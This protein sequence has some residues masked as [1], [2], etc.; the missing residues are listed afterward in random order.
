MEVQQ[1]QMV[2][3][4]LV[5]S[6]STV[7]RSSANPV[8]M[9]TLLVIYGLSACDEQPT[10]TGPHLLTARAVN[11]AAVTASECTP[12]TRGRGL[13]DRLGF[14]SISALPAVGTIRVGDT[15][16]LRVEGRRVDGT[17][18]V[19]E[20]FSTAV[21]GQALRVAS[22]SRLVG[23][24]EGSATVRVTCGDM[25]SEANITV[26]G[27]GA[28]GGVADS[29]RLVADLSVLRFDGR[30]D[31]A[32]VSN[33]IPLPAGLVRPVD[34][35]TLRVMVEGQEMAVAVGSLGA[36][37][38][39]GTVR[40]VLVQFRT[41]VP[42]LGA[43]RGQLRLGGL[44]T[45]A[46]IPIV[47]APRN[48]Q[49]VALPNSPE[50]LRQTGLTGPLPPKPLLGVTLDMFQHDADFGRLE[51]IDWARCGA[52]WSCGRTAGYD[53]ALSLYQEW[54]RTGNP[55]YFHHANANVDDYL[56]QYIEPNKVPAPWW[57]NSESIAINYL[58]TGAPSSRV[59][60]RK[61]AEGL[62]EWVRETVWFSQKVATGEDRDR[63]RALVAALDAANVGVL[64]PVAELAVTAAR[65]YL[66]S[67][68][69]E[70]WMQMM[71]LSQDSRGCFCSSYFSN[72][73]KNFMVGLYLQALI[74]YYDERRQ[75]PAVLTMIRKSADYMWQYEWD[76]QKRGFKY[77]TNA[78]YDATGVVVEQ[79][80]VFPDLN[81]LIAPA[82]A[83][84]YARTGETKYAEQYDL[85][86]RGIRQDPS[87]MQQSGKAFDQGYY[88][89]ANGYY[90]RFAR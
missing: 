10:G 51:G 45:A 18:A 82:Y 6:M 71:V 5:H 21:S 19:L 84:L 50:Y 74:R 44:R 46:S 23:A 16:G 36:L 63:A 2:E 90:W 79:P 24:G 43:L 72:G 77:V 14:T 87:W 29:G 58:V 41:T 37:Y 4:R 76:A 22:P 57:S 13:A 7:H 54:I 53:R 12:T 60:L 59:L 81:A 3:H 30:S 56:T 11:D 70:T 35:P 64:E 80:T 27:Q 17:S 15:V 25:M 83:W 31:L 65:P 40:A 88:R 73:Q 38:G 66:N 85:Q 33:G 89:M 62:A 9:L 20:H 61:V 34:V 28:K 49:V 55:V 68:T 86:M 32:L 8:A 75:D 78:R 39:D 67:S 26:E 47:V 42:A 69:L 52:A 48:P 1:S